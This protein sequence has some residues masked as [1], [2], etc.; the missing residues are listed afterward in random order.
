MAPLKRGGAAW[1]CVCMARPLGGFRPL[2]LLV[3]AVLSVPTC[4]FALGICLRRASE[5]VTPPQIL[6]L[7]VIAPRPLQSLVP[8]HNGRG[9]DQRR[10]GRPLR[11]RGAG[12]A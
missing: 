4:S 5:R 10:A 9:R 12:R 6:V 3:S 11:V 8:S 2:P 7:F 1:L